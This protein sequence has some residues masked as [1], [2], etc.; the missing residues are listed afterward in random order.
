MSDGDTDNYN[1]SITISNE[2]ITVFWIDD[3]SELIEGRRINTVSSDTQGTLCQSGSQGTIG[4]SFMVTIG[5]VS[6]TVKYPFFQEHF[7]R[8]LV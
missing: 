3:G 2:F 8:N 4:S 6:T 5:A 7:L 1:P